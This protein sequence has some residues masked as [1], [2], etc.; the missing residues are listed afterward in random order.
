MKQKTFVEYTGGPL[1]FNDNFFA[2]EEEMFDYHD[3]VNIFADAELCNEEK[4][5]YNL[6]AICLYEDIKER[7]FEE[8]EDPDRIKIQGEDE[9]IK[10]LQAFIDCQDQTIFVPNGKFVRLE[11]PEE[12]ANG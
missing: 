2:D 5:G 9:L 10:A 7:L 12:E 3:D 4:L 8:M 11:R 6:S 1:L